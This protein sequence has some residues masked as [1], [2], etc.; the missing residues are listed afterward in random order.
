MKLDGDG[1]RQV[2]RVEDRHLRDHGQAPAHRVDLE[3]AIELERLALQTLGIALVL[4]AQRVDL[5]LQ[6]LHRLHRA[7]ALDGQRIEQDLREDR[8]EDDGDTV[9]A[10]VAIHPVHELQNGQAEP[11]HRQPAPL[12][13]DGEPPEVQGALEPVRLEA[14]HFLGPDVDQDPTLPG[15]ARGDRRRRAHADRHLA[16]L[17]GLRVVRLGL[18]HG[19]ELE[20]TGL[21]DE[22][23]EV[24]RASDT[25]PASVDRVG[26]HRGETLDAL[27]VSPGRPHDLR[28][29]L[30][31]KLLRRVLRR[32][33]RDP[34]QGNRRG[35]RGG[36]R[37]LDADPRV[38]REVVRAEAISLGDPK[39]V[40]L[41]A[42]REIRRRMLHIE[43]QGV[44]RGLHRD[45]LRRALVRAD[46]QTG[47]AE[48]PDGDH[49]LDAS[50]LER[51]FLELAALAAHDRVVERR[52]DDHGALRRSQALSRRTRRLRRHGN[53]WCRLGRLLRRRLGLRRGLGA[54]GRWRFLARRKE[55][56]LVDDQQSRHQDS[57]QNRSLFHQLP[58]LAAGGGG[59]KPPG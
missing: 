42:E 50:I 35:P 57:R 23:D 29:V 26:P 24:P 5:R 22:G 33:M 37:I 32:R 27:Y 16:G 52:V 11:L 20:P 4:A 39:L 13:R 59:S 10:D 45:D 3:L 9:V 21:R 58:R 34:G 30:P 43:R 18:A 56:E 53:G 1:Q 25:H 31:E 40:V 2:E 49:R 47:R 14:P 46:E 41:A 12:A 15:L 36:G 6:R 38:D 51:P 48:L 19:R 44:D 8:D 7:H 17:A 28:G 55:Q 54:L